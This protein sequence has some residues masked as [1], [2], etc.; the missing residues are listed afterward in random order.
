MYQKTY[1]P[2]ILHTDLTQN[3]PTELQWAHTQRQKQRQMEGDHPKLPCPSDCCVTASPLTF[4]PSDRVETAACHAD[5]SKN[6]ER[7]ERGRLCR[8]LHSPRQADPSSAISCPSGQTHWK[9]PSVL[10]HSPP[11]HSRGFLSH[12]SMSDSA[13]VKYTHRHK[14]QY[15]MLGFR[16]SLFITYSCTVKEYKQQLHGW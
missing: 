10:T 9:L 4:L 6:G 2:H 5:S 1:I 12:S 7:R 11:R 15:L 16:H 13:H 14:K 3:T 8:T